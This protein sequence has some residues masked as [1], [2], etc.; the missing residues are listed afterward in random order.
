MAPSSKKRDG[1][2][3][4]AGELL[5]EWDPYTIP[6]ITELGGSVKF[7]DILEGTTMEEKVDERTGLS[8]KVIID[9]KDIDKRPRI[10]IKDDSGKTARLAS[11]NE[12]RY[13]VPVG[14]HINVIEHQEVSP[15]DVLAKIPRETTKTKDIHRRA[16]PR[17]RVVRG[18]ETQGVRRHQ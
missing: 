9:F 10:S 17:G 1:F 13:M 15:G 2:A 4:K 8:T 16:A 14:A 11:N 7:G 3:V 5:A 6:I 12:A 18:E